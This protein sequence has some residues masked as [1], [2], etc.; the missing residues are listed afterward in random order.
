VQQGVDPE[1]T[2]SDCL[3]S[4]LLHGALI[5]ST[6]YRYNLCPGPQLPAVKFQK[7][8]IRTIK[9]HFYHV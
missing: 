6:L 2:Y 8:S 1:V 9:E 5:A 7:M 3:D 4:Q